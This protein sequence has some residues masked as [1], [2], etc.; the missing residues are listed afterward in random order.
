MNAET[1]IVLALASLSA[2]PFLARARRGRSSIGA[3]FFGLL[4]AT[5]WVSAWMTSEDRRS[6][7]ERQPPGDRPIEARDGEYVS[8]E[9]CRSCHPGEYDSWHHSYHRSMTQEVTPEAVRGDFSDVTV[10]L[11]T[12]TY[13]F[14]RTGDKFWV[15]MDAYNEMGDLIPGAERVRREIVLITGSHHMQ[16]YWMASGFT[17]K[18]DSVP[19][20]WLIKEQKWI[21]RLSAFLVPQSAP[22]TTEA[23]RWND[24]C[25][26]CHATQGKPGWRNIHEMD[27]EVA[28]FG[29]ACEACHGPAGDHIRAY[30]GLR[31][32]YQAH[33]GSPSDA[34]LALPRTPAT[35]Q[36]SKLCG[37]CHSVHSG[38]VRGA[39]GKLHVNRHGTPFRPGGD[40]SETRE[41]IQPSRQ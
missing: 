30:S 2:I 18:L 7:K 12:G 10:E 20:V 37:Q 23:G 4:L 9:T 6:V 40:F 27:T 26:R 8:S 13:R 5:V 17:R 39:H 36:D 21:P 33:L 25:I 28:E 24:S 41:V 31:D 35:P 14:G 34:S 16:V 32:R 29:I 3:V 15:E 38:E 11:S 22:A 19:T 1:I